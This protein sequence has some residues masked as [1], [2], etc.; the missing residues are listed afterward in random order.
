MSQI[1]RLPFNDQQI[2][3]GFNFDSRENVG[4]ALLVEKI[5]EDP[6]VD[7]QIVRTSFH[8]VSTQESLMEA[9]GLSASADARYGLFAADA[10]VDFAQSH[11]VNSFSS[12]VAGRCE[13]Q[14]ATR[15]GRGFS[16]TALAA[17]L[18]NSGNT[19]Q[20]KRAF[21]DMF[22]RSLKTGG[23]FY[24]VARVTSVSAEHQSKL[25]ASLHAEYN[26][27]AAGGSFQAAFD[28]ATRETSGRTEVT[29]FMSQAGGIGGQASFTG[30]DATKILQRISE[31]P[32]FAHDHPVGYEA[33]LATY[34]TLAIAGPSVEEVEARKLVLADCLS[35]KLS[36]LKSL[37]DLKFAQGPSGATFFE[38]LPSSVELGDMETQ[39]RK[40]LNSLM[41]HAIQVSK[42]TINPP[43]LFVP[44]PP[45]PPVVFTKRLS[46]ASI[47]GLWEMAFDTGGESRWTFTPRS[48]NQF[49]AIED[50][51]GNARGIAVVTGTQV[52]L[53]WAASNPGDST[54]GR[55]RMEMNSDFTSATATVEFFTVHTHL[56]LLNGRFIRVMYDRR[57]V[58]AEAKTEAMQKEF[59]M[60]NYINRRS[61]RQVLKYGS[62]LFTVGAMGAFGTANATLTPVSSEWRFC[63][64]CQILFNTRYESGSC[65]AGGAHAAQGYRFYFRLHTPESP[66]AQ[67]KWRRCTKCQALFFNGYPGKG[68][69]PA[70]SGRGHSADT[71]PNMDPGIP[72]DIPGTPVA[73][74][75]WRFCNKCYGMFY[76]GY[77]A[78]GLCA[79]GGPHVAQGY[80]FVLPHDRP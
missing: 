64:K 25:T 66:T 14:N 15:H 2:G 9:L 40:A 3:Q 21:G 5:F 16:L 57:P 7:G 62:S 11:S 19:E 48:G 73:Q 10:K 32:Q 68:R 56:G 78:K 45:P 58:E 70:D 54:T 24:V 29:V 36:F 20:F 51:L 38:G 31:F 72:H 42:G 27:L 22:V 63:N 77:P 79:A 47:A 35:Q 60:F 67:K 12:F 50:G 44:D 52:E 55:F 74:T 43:T 46:S 13:V 53:D 26:G 18:I 6:V 65:A 8:S 4:T 59:S 39:Y 34:D 61:R 33:E 71:N 28:T 23:E 69:C 1:L 41:A 80:K 17:P 76:D 30:P 49:D 37:S 75:G